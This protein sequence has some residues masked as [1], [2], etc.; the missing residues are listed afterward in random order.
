M[1]EKPT[2]SDESLLSGLKNEFGL[3]ALRLDFLPLGADLNTAVYR[4]ETAAGEAYFVKLRKGNFEKAS[5]A[6]PDWLNR[7][8]VPGIIPPL[9]TLQGKLWGR[10]GSYRLILYPFIEG[11]DA[12]EQ[13][14]SQQQWIELGALLKALHSLLPPA[15]LRRTIR[16][17]DYSPAGRQSVAAFLELAQGSSFSDPLSAEMA[18]VLR[19]RRRQIERMLERAR[20]VRP[21]AAAQA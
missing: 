20:R 5:L 9:L 14:P 7:Q 6:L 13:P 3:A 4:A 2:L 21:R 16:R 12:Y 17:E 8:G 11:Q 10:L 1:L 19:T 15:A 18:G